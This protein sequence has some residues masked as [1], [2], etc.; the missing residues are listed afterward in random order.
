MGDFVINKFDEELAKYKRFEKDREKNIRNR[1]KLEGQLTEN[2]LV[3][4]ELDLLEEG[5]TVYKL[6]GP[7]LFKQ[8][9]TEAKQNVEKRIDYIIAEISR[10]EQAIADAATKQEN[11]KQTVMRLQ[12]AVTQ[13]FRTK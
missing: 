11:Q 4:T 8:D 7:V 6:I 13:R 12:N 3:K 5:A 9:L 1:Q 2:K 10:L